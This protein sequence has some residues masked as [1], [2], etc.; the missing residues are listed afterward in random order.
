MCSQ[1]QADTS[2]NF[3][4]W[5]INLDWGGQRSV[6]E[7][8]R[9][10]LFKVWYM[11]ILFFVFHFVL[12]FCFW[13]FFFSLRMQKSIV[14]KSLPWAL[15]ESGFRSWLHYLV[16]MCPW[17][18]YFSMSQLFTCYMGVV[19]SILKVKSKWVFIFIV[20]KVLKSTRFHKC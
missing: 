7:E 14:V 13:V 18:R 6:V 15:Y 3:K 10:F 11:E 12:F 5:D 4:A 9:V 2:Q 17:E 16:G 19:G 8:L 20:S 1:N